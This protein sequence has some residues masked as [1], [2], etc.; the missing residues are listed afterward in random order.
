MAS[1]KQIFVGPYILGKTIGVGSTGKLKMGFHKQSGMKVAVKIVKKA[2]MQQ[3]ADTRQRVEREVKVLRLL[4][5]PN[6]MKAHDVLQTST[7]LFIVLEYL[8]GGELYDYISDRPKL[9]IPEA[10]RFFYQL[11]TGVAYM[12]SQSICHRDIKLE[13]LLLDQ[14][15]N[16]KLADFGMASAIPRDGLLETS[17]GSPH[18]ACPEIVK[19]EKYFGPACDVWSCGV[20]LY[21]LVTSTLPFDSSQIDVLFEK[22]KCG[23]FYMPPEL[24]ASLR[25]LLSKMLKV[26]GSERITIDELQSHP[27][28]LEN[29]IHVRS[30]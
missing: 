28:W 5:H 1:D 6:I 17:C 26:N 11:V 10:F 25:D 4:N 12:H 13:N 2:V 22:I 27:F 24:P 21:A 15:G 7:H 23:K 20:L 19:G 30:G 29:L 3:N 8:E 16:L 14:H 9:T 18:Y